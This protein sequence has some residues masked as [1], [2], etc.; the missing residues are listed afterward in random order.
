MPESILLSWSGGK[1]SAFALHTLRSSPDFEP[2]GLLTTITE[3]YD[4]ISVHG[5]RRELLER[6][7]ESIGLPLHKVLIPKDCPNEIYEDRLTAALSAIKDQGIHHVAF[8]DLY[9]EDIRAYR[10]KQMAALGLEP[11]FPL[12]GRDTTELAHEIIHLGFRAVLVCVDT[13]IL[14]PVFAGRS[15]DEDL[16]RDLPP[17]VDLCGENGEFHTFVHAGPV[18][19]EP[20]AIKLG[21]VEGRGRFWFRDLE[22]GCAVKDKGGARAPL[23]SR[24]ADRFAGLGLTEDVPEL[25]GERAR[26]A[27]FES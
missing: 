1:D 8:G 11:V 26:P 21:R 15:F 5:V 13:D 24:L 20:V 16:L 6:Q 19:R 9:L 2:A 25:R 12:W 7:A 14:D 4:R 3:D 23:G 10:E 27:D 17:D 22:A 18:F